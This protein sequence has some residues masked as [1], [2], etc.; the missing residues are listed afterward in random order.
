M[1]SR[2]ALR[3]STR[4]RVRLRF[5]WT[6]LAVAALLPAC[7]G[8]NLFSLSAIAGGIL[9]PGVDI[10]APQADAN[11]AVGASVAVTAS[12]TSSDGATQVSYRGSFEGCSV[13]FVPQIV[14][15]S[16]NPQDTTL[17]TTLQQAPGGGTGIVAIIVE[18]TDLL[19]ARGADTVTV[20]IGS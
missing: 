6:A 5:V 10:T 20:V 12:V 8:E 9:G 14:T 16:G 15:L 17:T 4:R 3:P 18:A 13:A 19:G 2:Q 7:S 1:I 11:F